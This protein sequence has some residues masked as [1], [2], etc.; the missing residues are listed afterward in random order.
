M[1]TEM[2]TV[3]VRVDP[4]CPWAWLTSRWL[5]EVERVRPVRVTTALF[6]LAEK[7]R[8]EEGRQRDSH[9]AGERALRVLVG[10]RRVGGDE[11]LA[12]LYAAIGEAYQERAEPLGDETTLEAAARVAGVDPEVARRSLEDPSTLDELLAEHAEAIA[13]G[14]FGVPTLE[15]DGCAPIFGPVVETRLSGE[16]A[17]QLWDHTA[18]L[19]RHAPFFELKRERSSRAGVGRYAAAAASSAGAGS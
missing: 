10:A 17:G 13:R 9:A 8:G 6:D 1:S 14:A 7:N 11:A 18:W 16:E 3:L 5:V 12:R 19:I 15:L 2:T 4:A